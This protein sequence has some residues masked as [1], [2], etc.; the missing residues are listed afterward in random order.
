[1]KNKTKAIALSVFITAILFS[2]VMFVFYRFADKIPLEEALLKAGTIGL[3]FGI[4][5]GITQVFLKRK[6]ST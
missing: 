6:E 5:R 2:A 1:M 4:M 3:L